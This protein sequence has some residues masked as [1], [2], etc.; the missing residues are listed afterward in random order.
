M[1]GTDGQT[2][3]QT[4]SPKT[5]SLLLKGDNT[6]KYAQKAAYRNVSQEIFN[7][8]LQAAA[9]SLSARTTATGIIG[10][11][12]ELHV[13]RGQDRAV[14]VTLQLR[15]TTVHHKLLCNEMP[16]LQ[17]CDDHG[18]CSSAIK[19]L[20]FSVQ[21]VRLTFA[22]QLVSDETLGVPQ[23]PARALLVSPLLGS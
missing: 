4:D 10:L 17:C 18:S 1:S 6:Y 2:D 8:D 20:G 22:R 19:H 9:L 16:G 12:D 7:L 23:Q 11:E 5:L 14:N 21:S 13:R 3:R 15:H